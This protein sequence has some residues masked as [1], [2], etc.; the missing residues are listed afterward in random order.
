[1]DDD[2]V[3]SRRSAIKDCQKIIHDLYI[4]T[5]RGHHTMLLKQIGDRIVKAPRGGLGVASSMS[6]RIP[7]TCITSL[8]S[9]PDTE[10]LIDDALSELEVKTSSIF[11][12]WSGGPCSSA[13]EFFSGIYSDYSRRAA[14]AAAATQGGGIAAVT[15]ARK[16]A[17]ITSHRE[18]M[19]P[20]DDL[21][22]LYI[23]TCASSEDEGIGRGRGT[24][25]ATKLI[26][27]VDHLEYFDHIL[28][29]ILVALANAYDDYHIPIHI[30]GFIDAT[31]QLPL[32][33]DKRAQSMVV[34][35]VLTTK[36][37]WDLY[38]TFMSRVL[39][40]WELPVCFPSRV[41]AWTHEYFWRSHC[42][43]RETLDK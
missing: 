28:P 2:T 15:G 8:L 13:F 33:M 3:D 7:L 18:S 39:A 12:R 9:G 32:R 5:I 24:N 40:T 17:S 27:A 43:L 19:A 16:A 26:I 1:L 36:A 10:F 42:C 41:I 31:C 35:D 14:A 37:P 4:K 23:K 38:D 30:I 11:A 25:R 34:I 20:L 29:D 22:K 21:H 6:Y